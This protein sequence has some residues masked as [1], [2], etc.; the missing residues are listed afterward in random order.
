[1]AGNMPPPS[2]EYL[3]ESKA[4][5]VLAIITVFPS[6]AAIV[7]SLR[8]YTRWKIVHSASWEDYAILGALV[9]AHLYGVLFLSV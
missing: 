2:Q 6:L 1:M 5:Y 3:N 7:V 9:S 4:S 8:L